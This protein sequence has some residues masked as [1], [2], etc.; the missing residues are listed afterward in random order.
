LV[1]L[2]YCSIAIVKSIQILSGKQSNLPMM[3]D[4]VWKKRH[5]A[6]IIEKSELSRHLQP[7][8]TGTQGTTISCLNNFDDEMGL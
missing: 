5:N 6:N 4:F 2:L 8:V 3:I 1:E 7:A